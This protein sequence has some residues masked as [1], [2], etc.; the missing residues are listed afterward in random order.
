MAT[1]YTQSEQNIYKTYF[2]LAGFFLLIIAIGWTLSYVMESIWILWV[3]VA[4]SI[5]MSFSSYWFSDKIVLSLSKAKLIE[6][7]DYPELWRVTENLAISNGLPMPRLF[8]LDDPQPNAFATGRNPQYGVVAVTTGLLERLEKA[9]LEA[10]IAHELAHIGNS[11]ILIS[12]VV[13]VLVGVVVLVADF[14]FRMAFFGG[15]GGRDSRGSLPVLLGAVA[16]I[17]IA[18]ILAQLLK[19]AVSRKR[20]YLADSTAALTTRYPEGLARALE[21]IASDSH[22]LKTA[23]DATA[24]LY[25]T[26]PFRGKEQKSWIRKL[27]MTHPPIED[28]IKKLREMS[29]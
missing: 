11:D 29:A 1:L 28:R 25:I 2:Y 14:F 5:V 6:K 21:K 8:I 23:N 13:V 16:F 17:I 24:H 10:V 27:F 20:E 12:S 4:V 7:K 19:L 9:E 22:Q 3:A 15:M 26:S 18:P